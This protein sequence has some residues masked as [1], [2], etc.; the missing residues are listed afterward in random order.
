V[1]LLPAER[2]GVLAIRAWIESDGEDGLRARITWTVDVMEQG[3]ASTAASTLEAITKV[4]AEWLR[5]FLGAVPVT[6][7]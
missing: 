3:E 1:A 5:T 4:V 6:L 2:P 7:P